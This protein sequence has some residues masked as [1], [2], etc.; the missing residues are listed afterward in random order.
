MNEIKRL[1]NT[2]IEVIHAAFEDAF[3]DY[4]VA[5]SMPVENLEE[6]MRTRSYRPELSIGY[7]SDSALVGFVLVGFR[8]IEGK[9]VCYDVATGVIRSFQKKGIGD[10][11]LK[12]L[13]EMVEEERIDSFLLEVLVNNIPAQKLYERH[14]FR[15]TR[16]LNCFEMPKSSREPDAFEGYSIDD[17][18]LRFEQIDGSLY[19][20]F[21]PSW[22]NAWASF[23][24]AADT[25]R[26]RSLSREGELVAYGIVHGER[27]GI[28]QIGL[29]P[30]HRNAR[31][32]AQILQLLSESTKSEKLSYLNVESGSALEE[33][34]L[35]LGCAG[36][37]DQYEMEYTAK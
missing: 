8:M 17:P 37:V 25:Y 5:I 9:R 15:R 3:S 31:T 7:F 36:T 33:I 13:L 19:T 1:G 12:A 28:L 18:A 11:L 21:R 14:G 29:A 6:M 2:S 23:R 34:I 20:S 22:Q 35:Q 16:R 27:G 32:L 26:L 10:E 4:E 30:A 24:N